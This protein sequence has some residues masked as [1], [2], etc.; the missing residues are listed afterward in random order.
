[1]AISSSRPEADH[2]LHII[3]ILRR[4]PMSN[5]T[6][7]TL[8]EFL[9]PG[10][11]F[12]TRTGEH[13]VKTSLTQDGGSP[14]CISLATGAYVTLPGGNAEPVL[15]LRSP[16]QPID[17]FLLPDADSLHSVLDEILVEREDSEGKLQS[18]F[19]RILTSGG[20]AH[21]FCTAYL[22]ASEVREAAVEACDK[23]RT[24]LNSAGAD[25]QAELEA[26]L[27]RLDE[28][29]ARIDRWRNELTDIGADT[30]LQ[31]LLKY[32]NA[33]CALLPP[34]SPEPGA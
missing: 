4:S 10:A 14:L 24:L 8:L 28:V 6:Q 3:P 20:I 1:M 32:R 26:A 29:T 22:N 5:T 2:P 21:S 11:L 19:E 12:L 17:D 7:E 33:L 18:V 13:A 15:E 31:L 34:P 16:L 23:A 9:R 25:T 30:P 27:A